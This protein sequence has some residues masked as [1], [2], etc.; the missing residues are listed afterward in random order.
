MILKSN[1]DVIALTEI[2]S[3]KNN[4]HDDLP[5]RAILKE[6]NLHKNQFDQ[7]AN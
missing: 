7:T 3:A 4:E 6:L 5:M 1:V 2:N